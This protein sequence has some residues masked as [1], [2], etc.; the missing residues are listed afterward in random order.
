MKF[1]SL[2][3]LFLYIYLEISVFVIVANTIGVLFALLIL[4]A[5]SILGIFIVKSQGVRHIVQMQ[6]K[7]QMGENPSREI[8]KSVLL[9]FGGFLLLIPGFITDVVG[10]FLLIPP[11]QRLVVKYFFPRLAVKSRYS[12]S[13]AGT[14]NTTKDPKPSEDTIEGT[15]I[16]KDDE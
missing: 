15:F 11:V 8:S 6:R 5:T 9:F 12:Y 4:V 16:R 1:V 2:I 13:T 7:L 14:N 3:L 10:A